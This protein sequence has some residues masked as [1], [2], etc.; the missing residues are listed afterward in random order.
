MGSRD[1]HERTFDEDVQA[2]SS[3]NP[4]PESGGHVTTNSVE[5]VCEDCGL[6]LESQPIDHGP[7]WRSFEDDKTN[8]ERT[9]APLTPARHDRGLSTEIGYKTDGSGNTLSGSKRCQ[10]GR[11]R[12]EHNRGR[13]RSKAERNLGH[14]LS[15]TRRVASALD[16]PTSIRDQAC[17]L[18]RTVRSSEVRVTR[19]SFGDGRLKRSPPQ[20]PTQPVAVTASHAR[21]R[22]SGT[23]RRS[24]LIGSITPTTSSIANSD[25]Q[26]CRHPPPSTSPGSHHDVTSRTKPATG[27]R[28][29]QI[30][31]STTD[32]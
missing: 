6:V 24:L 14:G 15:E 12:R 3:A 5:T 16:L 17:A 21:P 25:C 8:S 30:A 29:S 7:E 19:T 27:R 18:F 4:C 9:G 11:L 28:R 23:S 2:D 31:P 32:S 22:R 10:L 13:W 20:A 1:I 26:P